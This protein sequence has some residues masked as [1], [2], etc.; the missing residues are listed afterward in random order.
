MEKSM[1][2][3]KYINDDAPCGGRDRDNYDNVR[4]YMKLRGLSFFLLIKINP[5]F[6]LYTSTHM[7]LN[8][9]KNKTKQI[10]CSLATNVIFI[11]TQYTSTLKFIN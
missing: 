6:S 10:L 3:T 1:Y 8:K 5:T 4:S 11:F 9:K 7:S 2:P